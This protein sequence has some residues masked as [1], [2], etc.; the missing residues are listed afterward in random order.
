VA[1]VSTR[2]AYPAHMAMERLTDAELEQWLADRRS[3]ASAFTEDDLR[4][5]GLAE[6]EATGD[7]VPYVT[8][9]WVKEYLQE[10]WEAGDHMSIMARTN[11][12]KSHLLGHVTTLC[13]GE[14]LVIID[15][16]GGDPV[17]D[18]LGR[19]VKSY[20]PPWL[21]DVRAPDWM[22]SDE[23]T[24]HDKAWGRHYR[25][26]VPDSLR[27]RGGHH[28]IEEAREEVQ[29]ALRAAYRNGSTIVAI[30]EIRDLTD[31]RPPG[32]GLGQLVDTMFRKARVRKVSLVAATQA[33]RYAGTSF[34]D[35]STIYMI[36]SIL[37]GRVRQRL[38]EIGGDTKRL[39]RALDRLP[40]R[41]FVLVHGRTMKAFQAPSKKALT[42][43]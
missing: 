27:K 11:M 38:D 30:D 19:A 14:E 43:S 20:P 4:E 5:L 16:K 8:W 40:D 9:E 25:V 13:P 3:G 1:A 32:L 21:S 7:D 15:T 12:G 41:H 28:G 34:Y 24:A 26:V 37:D 17:L 36:G 6:D 31:A 29:K 33:P 42:R 39:Q 18:R 35:Q 23:R 22:V 10:N 2:R